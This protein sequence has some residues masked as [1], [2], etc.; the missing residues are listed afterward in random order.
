[1]RIRVYAARQNRGDKV[2]DIFIVGATLVV[3]P[4]MKN[5]PSDPLIKG[6]RKRKIDFGM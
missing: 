3:V 2:V 1:M 5:I 4:M 6:A